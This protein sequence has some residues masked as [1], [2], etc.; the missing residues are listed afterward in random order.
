MRI[1]TFLF[2]LLSGN[3]L[4]QFAPQFPL[5][6][7]KAIHR[8]D[9][10]ILEW[11]TN[12]E[13]N[14]SYINIEDTAMGLAVYGEAAFATGMADNKVVSLGDG[15]NAILSFHNSIFNGEGWD[16]VVFE[17]GFA[18]PEDEALAY[19]ELAFVE[20]STD[21]VKYVRFP[22]TSYMHTDT[23]ISNFGYVDAKYYNNLAG[24][25]IINYGTPFDLNDLKDSAGIDIDNIN[26]VKIVDVVG[27]L[28]DNYAQ[29]DHLGN[30]INDPWPSLY[31]SSGFDLDAVGVLHKN[32]TSAIEN[33]DIKYNVSIYP[34][35]ATDK[36]FIE[37]KYPRDL[38]AT[39]IDIYGRKMSTLLLPSATT[40]DI[41]SFPNGIYFLQIEGQSIPFLKK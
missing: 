32:T 10:R 38:S 18:N 27:S 4:A 34:N 33:Y 39:I 13:L 8:S 14:N 19:L 26:F 35:P 30:K 2:L 9:S 5:D 24:K 40:I 3:A 25:Y 15:G 20:V 23:Q 11:A 7:H 16:F 37:H 36:L 29:Y 31:S 21:G 12:C 1:L 17:N 28:K 41:I 22:A 6:G